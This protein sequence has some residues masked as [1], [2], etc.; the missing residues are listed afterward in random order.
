MSRFSVK[1]CIF[2]KIFYFSFTNISIFLIFANL[3]LLFAEMCD[4]IRT[5][6]T[7][8]VKSFAYRAK[9]NNSEV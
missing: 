7:F 3:L 2:L 1:G 4:K 9:H 6:M 8:N 5:L